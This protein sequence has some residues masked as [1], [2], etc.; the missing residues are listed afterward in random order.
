MKRFSE[1]FR[2]YMAVYVPISANLG[3]ELLFQENHSPHL[4]NTIF[5][6]YGAAMLISYNYKL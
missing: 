1:L 2:V 6:N 5:T 3:I 4:L